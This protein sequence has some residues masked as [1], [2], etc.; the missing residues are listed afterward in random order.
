MPAV[1]TG[2]IHLCQATGPA[3]LRDSPRKLE[4]LDEQSPV[5]VLCYVRALGSHRVQ[6]QD[7][8]T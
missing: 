2:N 3:E 1:I 8:R 4:G 7:F 6:T 5:P